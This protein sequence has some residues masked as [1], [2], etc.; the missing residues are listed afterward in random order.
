MINE[1]M[2]KGGITSSLL[3]IILS[4]FCIVNVPVASAPFYLC[5]FSLM[6]NL[7]FLVFL[8]YKVIRSN[9]EE[10]K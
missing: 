5:L 8:I 10:S 1:G 9:R 2:Y 6:I 3:L 7:P 4:V